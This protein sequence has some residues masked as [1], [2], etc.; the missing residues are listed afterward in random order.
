VIKI[1]KRK[2]VAKLFETKKA[3]SFN[4]KFEET[5]TITKLDFIR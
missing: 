1:W 5:T 3:T 2:S 4:L